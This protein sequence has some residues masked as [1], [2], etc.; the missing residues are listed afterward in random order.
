MK[1]LIISLVVLCSFTFANAINSVIVQ[2]GNR[3]AIYPSI[4]AAVAAAQSGD[5]IYISGS[6]A[7]YAE[8]ITISKPL[9]IYGAGWVNSNTSA[10]G[11]TTITGTFTISNGANNLTITGLQIQSIIFSNSSELNNVTITRCYIPGRIYGSSSSYFKMSN[12]KVSEC[13]LSGGQVFNYLKG[14]AN[15]SFEKNFFADAYVASVTGNSNYDCRFTN[16]IFLKDTAPEV[17]NYFSNSSYNYNAF[18][19]QVTDC[20][21]LNNIFL[22]NNT[23]IGKYRYYYLEANSDRNI[24]FNNFYNCGNG[25]NFGNSDVVTSNTYNSGWSGANIFVKFTSWSDWQN[26]DFHINDICG[27]KTAGSDGLEPGIYGSSNPFKDGW[28]MPE[29]PQIKSISVS[30]QTDANGQVTVTAK[31]EGQSK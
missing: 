12:F 17:N 20:A 29:N 7:V 26:C 22:T 19:Y 30:T 11:P 31:V 27:L 16:N 25:G 24:C 8:S 21:F 6:K 1:K 5:T 4:T 3:M 10:T 14:T 23:S 13:W 2:N 9:T 28:F 15:C 18:I